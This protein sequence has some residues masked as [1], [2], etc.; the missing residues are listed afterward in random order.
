MADRLDVRKTYKLYLDGGFVRSESGR[1]DRIGGENVARGSRK[2][3]RDAVVAAR[4][5]HQRW[6]GA[7][8]Q[9]RGFVLYRLAE[10]ME[11]RACGLAEQLV[12]G[13]TVASDEARR[14]VE[15]A[16]DRTVWYAGWCD[17]YLAFASARNPV[18]GPHFNFS[19][20]ERSCRRW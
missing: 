8:A 11:S 19:T 14:E 16:V 18:S 2:E 7:T 5:A 9:N 20:S 12:R 3:V 6:A 1:T 15:A 4:E 17:K 10:M 13:G